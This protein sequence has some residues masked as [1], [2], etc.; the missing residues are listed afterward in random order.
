M[1]Q[2]STLFI[3]IIMMLSTTTLFAGEGMWIP[4]FLKALNEKEMQDMGMRISAEDIYSINQA[5]LK[6]AI[7]IFGGGCTGELVSDEGLLLTNHHCGYGSIQKHSSIDHDYLTDGF[8][9]MNRGEELPNPGLSV[10]FLVRM[11]DVTRQ[12]LEVVNDNMSEAQRS[13]AVDKIVKEITKEA[14]KDTHYEAIIKPFY[15]GNEYYMFVYEKYTDVRLVGAPPSNIGKFGGDTDNWM[16]PRHTGDFSIFR[17][18]AD[19]DNN[20]AEY[21]EENIPYTPKA[22]LSI[23]LKGVKENDFT[24][25]FGYPGTTTEYVSSYEVESITEV[26]NPVAIDLRTK[27]LDVIKTAMNKDPQVRIQYSAK[28]AGIANG[29]KKMI[30]ENRGIKKLNGLENKQAFE[31]EFTTWAASSPETQK[32]YGE[33]LPAFEAI[34]TDL[35]PLR[36]TFNY[37]I[38]AGM[39]VEI[40]RYAY[41][42]NRLIS[43]SKDKNTPD[44]EIDKMVERLQASTESFFKDYVKDIDKN[45]FSAVMADYY[46]NSNPQY[47][48]EFFTIAHDKYKGDFTAYAD[49]VYK[50]TMF[51]DKEKAMAFLDNY[52]PSKYKKISKDPAFQIAKS[53][54]NLYF[55]KIAPKSGKLEQQVDSLMRIYM[56]GQMEMQADKRFYP[57]A[58][59]TLRITYGNVDGFLPRDGVQYNYFTTLDGIMEKEDPEI[60]DYVVEERLKELYN[61]KDYGRY[62]DADGHMHV[63]FT[64]SNHTTGGNSGSPVLNADGHLIGL[65]F[66][67]NWEGTMSDLMYDPDQCRNITLDVRYC[68]FIIDKFAGAGHLVDEMTLVE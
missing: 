66:D 6:D 7:V 21:S 52:K 9:A 60:Y 1:K 3:A 15:Y 46:N 13:E 38:N 45:V 36:E 58:N 41:G 22:H 56:K 51:A 55:N 43:L 14:T 30:G 24:F 53:I 67:R 19:K 5:C 42:F 28:A 57:D 2:L 18:Y 31:A 40:V 32:Q 63:C 4:L 11:E 37:L 8:W 50:K 26:E 34:Y 12:I 10:T 23:S 47:A 39:G 44:E 64:A 54:Y 65:N 20:P 61:A 35:S 68:L 16:W 33:V 48:P 59:F 25:V 17:V 29:W 62:G 49:D 27:R